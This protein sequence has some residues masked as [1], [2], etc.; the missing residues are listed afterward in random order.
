MCLTPEYQ[1]SFVEFPRACLIGNLP[2]GAS[3]NTME[4]SESD[5]ACAGE[6]DHAPSPEPADNSSPEPDD[7]TA[8]GPNLASTCSAPDVELPHQACTPSKEQGLD[9]SEEDTFLCSSSCHEVI[10]PVLD[11]AIWLRWCGGVGG[12]SD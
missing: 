7:G 6:W 3:D 10:R 5:E 1:S 2:A 12:A 8:A 4:E 11:H 9:D